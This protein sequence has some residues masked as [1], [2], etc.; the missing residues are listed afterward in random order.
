MAIHTDLSIHKS[1]CDLLGV[2]IEATKHMPRDFKSS[3]G[4]D[5]RKLC[6]SMILSVMRANKTLNASKVTHIDQVLED[7]EVF[8]DLFRVCRHPSSGSGVSRGALARCMSWRSQPMPYA[9]TL[10]HC[11]AVSL[12][13]RC[14]RRSSGD[15]GGRPRGRLVC[16]MG[17]LYSNCR[18]TKNALRCSIY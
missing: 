2:S 16:S 13:E 5:I 12:M 4:A 8:N 3:L 17:A 9:S 7:V 6:I 18:D 14:S 11:A 1:C 15:A 10:A